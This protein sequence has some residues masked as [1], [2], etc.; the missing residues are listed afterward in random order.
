MK[1]KPLIIFAKTE[2]KRWWKYETK[3]E[4]KRIEAI[5]NKDIREYRR[6]IVVNRFVV[7]CRNSL[8]AHKERVSVN[9][10]RNYDKLSLI[11]FLS[12]IFFSG[13]FAHSGMM[14]ESLLSV[15]MGFIGVGILPHPIDKNIK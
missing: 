13:W 6:N 15:V 9:M 5:P 3:K 7:R 2:R 1:L 10:K 8:M 11:V 14:F 4:D 12:G